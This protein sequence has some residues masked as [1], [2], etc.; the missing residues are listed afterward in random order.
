MPAAPLTV[1][2]KW[3][4]L[5]SDHASPLSE[6]EREILQLVATGATNQEIARTLYISVNTVKVHVR[7]IFTKLGV[8]SRTEA[9]MV[10]LREGWVAVKGV[11]PEGTE[12]TE[13]V[14]ADA[15]P[16]EPLSWSRRVVLIL[17]AAL[18]LALL[19]W[20]RMPAAQPVSAPG[21]EFTD[22][23]A[24]A[25]T[26]LPADV[27]RWRERVPLALPRA[28][29]A[30]AL[31]DG[32]IYAI[33]GETAQGIT[34]Q[35]SRYDLRKDTWTAV[36]EK[37]TPAANI[38]AVILEGRIYVPGGYTAEGQVTDALEIYDPRADRWSSGAPLPVACCA[39]GLAALEGELYLFGGWDGRGYLS[40]AY[41]YDPQADG[42]SEVAP[43]PDRR[44]FVAA[45]ALN[46]RIYV[47][48]GYDGRQEYSLCQS[49][50]PRQGWDSC[51]PM[52]VG[53]GA[54]GLVA[55]GGRLYAIGGGISRE[56]DMATNEWY[57]PRQN[58]WT[59][60]D[61]PIIGQW[62][63]PGVTADGVSIFAVGGWSGEYLADTREYQALF[64]LFLPAAP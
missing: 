39:Y 16:T 1:P 27:P 37:P 59:P 24:M 25:Y 9:T 3:R 50:D 4:P 10:A 52:S 57:D 62:R 36:A 45:A 44:G 28:R 18:S 53:R 64:R 61:T 12:A 13:A 31:H 55:L 26:A 17:A 20:V 15:V 60:F 33:G 54:L 22:Q 41:R 23:S 14:V 8:A 58:A 48:G 47:V 63:N 5:M 7:N 11:I 34:G 51:A 43:L 19:V 40:S 49:Y 46:G 29:L 35:V 21:T 42:W 56:G 2:G 30:V 32:Q 6:R 38:S